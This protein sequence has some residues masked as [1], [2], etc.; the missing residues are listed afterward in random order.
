M[1]R[2]G[3]HL[4]PKLRKIVSYLYS[5]REC[6]LGFGIFNTVGILQCSTNF[7]SASVIAFEM[8]IRPTILRDISHISG[9]P[10]DNFDVT[11][12]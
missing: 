6:I 10:K 1:R 9:P 5:Q 4:K 2:G 3:G 8:N 7:T 12:D 11:D